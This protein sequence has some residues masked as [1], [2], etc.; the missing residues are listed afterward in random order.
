[1]IST[2]KDFENLPTKDHPTTYYWNKNDTP[3][4][5]NVMNG[6][7]GIEM[8]ATNHTFKVYFFDKSSATW[9]GGE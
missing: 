1:M 7:A 3:P 9:V 2:N 8:D 4:T 5:V 6:A